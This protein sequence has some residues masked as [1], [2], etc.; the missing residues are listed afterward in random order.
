MLELLGADINIESTAIAPYFHPMA[1]GRYMMD[2]EVIAEFGRIHPQVARE[3]N[4]SPEASYFECYLDRLQTHTLSQSG[5][6]RSYVE[7]NKYPSIIR[8]LNFIMGERAPTG[9]IGEMIAGVD[10]R[11]H[12]LELVGTYQGA[13]IAPGFKSATYRFVIEDRTKTI[14]DEEALTL[15][16]EVITTL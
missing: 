6:R 1:S 10:P 14:T 3:F 2:G 9:R 4:L 13:G 16:N 5:L 8:E 15:Q 7:P 11:I 12:S